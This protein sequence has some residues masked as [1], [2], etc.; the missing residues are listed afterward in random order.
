MTA[1]RTP[2]QIFKLK[3]CTLHKNAQRPCGQCFALAEEQRAQQHAKEARY[4]HK[5]YLE[6]LMEVRRGSIPT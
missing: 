5:I 2:V 6:A 1:M 3:K 4:L